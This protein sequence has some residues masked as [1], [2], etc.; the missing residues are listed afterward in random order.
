MK[1]EVCCPDCNRS[2]NVD[3]DAGGE[4]LCPTCMTRIPLDGSTTAGDQAAKNARQLR[5]C[6]S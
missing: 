5:A 4:M 3:R 2:W 1:I 6:A